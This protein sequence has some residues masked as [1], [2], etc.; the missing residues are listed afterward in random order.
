[1]MLGV[2]PAYPTAS[3]TS[4]ASGSWG[5]GAFSSAGDWFQLKWPGS[6][7]EVHITVT[8]EAGPSDAGVITWQR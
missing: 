6:W 1:M 4:D 5:C 2:V 7:S 8:G 3:I